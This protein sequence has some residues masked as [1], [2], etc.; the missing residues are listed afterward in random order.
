M[1]FETG[2]DYES[3]Q[4]QNHCQSTPVKRNPIQLFSQSSQVPHQPFPTLNRCTQHYKELQFH[5]DRLTPLFPPTVLLLPVRLLL[6]EHRHQ[7]KAHVH[8][9]DLNQDAF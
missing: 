1:P 9:Q 7:G 3:D 2:D 4:D 8:H 5:V 6:L